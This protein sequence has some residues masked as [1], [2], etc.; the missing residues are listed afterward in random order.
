MKYNLLG[1]RLS[2]PTYSILANPAVPFSPCISP[3]HPRHRQLELKEHFIN[4]PEIE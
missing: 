2:Y 3:T 4:Y 1:L